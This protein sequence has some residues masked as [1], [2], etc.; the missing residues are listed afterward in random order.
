MTKASERREKDVVLPLE[1]VRVLLSIIAAKTGKL[2]AEKST[3]YRLHRVLRSL[4]SGLCPSSEQ[5]RIEA[6]KSNAHQ[7]AFSPD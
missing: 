3:K 4:S 5:P 2:C 7:T 6:S 1:A